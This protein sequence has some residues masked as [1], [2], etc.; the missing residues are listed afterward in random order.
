MKSV[1][2]V[3]VDAGYDR[4]ESFYL[5]MVD[6]REVGALRKFRDTRSDTHP[7]Q[8]FGVIPAGATG[9]DMIR[10]YLGLFYKSDGYK[11]AALDAVLANV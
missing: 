9:R 4:R 6:G 1:K 7:W 2:L 8:A 11:G 10:P 5:V 3:K